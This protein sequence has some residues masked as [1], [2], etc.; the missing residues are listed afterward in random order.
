MDGGGEGAGDIAARG[1]VDAARSLPAEAGHGRGCPTPAVA[2]RRRPSRPTT[3]LAVGQKAGKRA[4]QQRMA[5]K[6]ER[7]AAHG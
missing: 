3:L 2:C 7:A 1:G 6:T 5:G 4:A